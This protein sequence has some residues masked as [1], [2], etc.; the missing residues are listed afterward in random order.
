[1]GWVGE[2][3]IIIVTDIVTDIG[4]DP[5]PQVIECPLSGWSILIRIGYEFTNEVLC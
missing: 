4:A 5:Y 2:S 1:M 3:K